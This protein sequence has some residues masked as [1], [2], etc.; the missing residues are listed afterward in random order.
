MALVA[1]AAPPAGGEASGAGSTLAGGSASRA[2][3]PPAGAA[4]VGA[5][6]CFGRGGLD[7]SS[8]ARR[9]LRA[10]AGI[11]RDRLVALESPNRRRPRRSE[12]PVQRGGECADK[13]GVASEVSQPPGARRRTEIHA[14][15]PFLVEPD[16]DDYI[17]CAAREAPPPE[18]LDDAYFLIPPAGMP[19]GQ[20]TANEVESRIPYAREGNRVGTAHETLI[21]GVGRRSRSGRHKRM[22]ETTRE[23][24]FLAQRPPLGSPIRCTEATPNA[25]SYVGARTNSIQPANPTA[26]DQPNTGPMA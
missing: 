23:R 18:G 17:A 8:I 6:V 26:L 16:V 3:V 21:G 11:D 9:G 14:S 4:L 19:A 25:L 5:R 2:G 10:L 24:S 22:L 15:L 12:F 1:P 13:P 7:G 20:F